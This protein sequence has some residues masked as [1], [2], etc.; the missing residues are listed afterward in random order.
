MG[1]PTTIDSVPNE[2]LLSILSLIPTR[3]LLSVVGVS[4]RF[5]S[6]ALRVLH[7]RLKT[8]AALPD[9]RL[10]LECYHPSAKISTPYLYC[11]HLYTDAVQD[12]DEG[13]R[14]HGL[15]TPTLGQLREVYAHFRPVAQEEN[16]RARLRYP[17]R[18]QPQSETS[19]TQGDDGTPQTH[20]EQ[21]LSL[22]IYLDDNEPFSQLCTAT[23]LVKVGPKPGWFLS[24]LNMTDDVIRVWRGWLAAQASG[25][26]TPTESEQ[27]STKEAILWADSAHNVG[28][29]FHVTE[30]EAEISARPI[31]VAQGEDLAV[32]YKLEYD[33]L[34]VRGSQLLLMTEKSEEQRE[35]NT[36][37]KA[38]IIASI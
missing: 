13:G 9:L 16:R 8:A 15:P 35:E 17:R 18:P 22:D 34:L 37:G 30:K 24:H 32:A 29:R 38:I 6:V 3:S 2:L 1:H 27:E 21:R 26:L 33:E 19:G 4:R 36:S 25:H 7:Y 11:D 10:I 31:L 12:G 5:Y 20:T 14:D 23:S 28:L